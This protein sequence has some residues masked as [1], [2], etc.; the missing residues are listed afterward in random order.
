M[1]ISG[2]LT[3]QRFFFAFSS[4]AVGGRG[5]WRPAA[6]FSNTSTEFIDKTAVFFFFAFPLSGA[7]G[8]LA[9]PPAL[10]VAEGSGWRR[11][12]V[13]AAVRS[14][15]HVLDVSDVATAARLVPPSILCCIG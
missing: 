8:G 6:V 3:T 1:R 9:V 5:P 7:P 11:W 12:A 10:S 14:G 15:A 4:H 13:A 2:S